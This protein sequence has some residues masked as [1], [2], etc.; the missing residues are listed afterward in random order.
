MTTEVKNADGRPVLKA[1]AKIMEE[2]GAVEKKGRNNFHNYD[3]ATAADV[4]HALQKRMAE[5]GLVIVPNQTKFELLAG[6][7]LLAIEFEFLVEHVSGDKLDERPRFTGMA[8]AKNSK[9]GMDDKAANK[10]L[11][12]ASKYFVLNLFRIPTGDYHDADSD[13][14]RPMSRPE[15]KG[16]KP[17]ETP[18]DEQ[19]RSDAR[20]EA[21]VEGCLSIIRVENDAEALRRWWNEQ[22]ADRRKHRLVQAEVDRLKDA[23]MVRLDELSTP[24]K[25][26]AE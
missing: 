22:G 12:A 18:F 14:E 25:E 7:N 2:V 9:G 20:A 24:Q 19:S 4:A 13:A 15:S 10:C 17:T 21:Y 8:S 5:A 3:Y 23:V 11:T 6:D 16:Q 1:I 26:A